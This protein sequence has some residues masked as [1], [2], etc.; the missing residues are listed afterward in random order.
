[1]YIK[2]KYPSIGSISLSILYIQNGKTQILRLVLS[3]SN[4][5]FSYIYI[6]KVQDESETFNIILNSIWDIYGNDE[7]N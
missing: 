7:S 2:N 1:M 5:R 3:F 6:R 4:I